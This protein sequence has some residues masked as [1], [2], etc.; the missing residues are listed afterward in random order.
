MLRYAMLCYAMPCYA[1]PCHVVIRYAE[2]FMAINTRDGNQNVVRGY[3]LCYAVECRRIKSVEMHRI[4]DG[5]GCRFW[6]SMNE[7]I[8]QMMP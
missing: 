2:S 7:R 4:I 6:D 8:E 1:M 3:M 5:F